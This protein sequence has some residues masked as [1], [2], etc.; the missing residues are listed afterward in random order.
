MRR[1]RSLRRQGP[2]PAQTG[3]LLHPDRAHA[4]TA[5]ADGERDRLDGGRHDPYR[6]RGACCS[7]PTSSSGS[8]PR[9]NIVLRDDKSYPWLMLTEDHAFP[10]IVKHRGAQTRQGQLLGTFRLR[11]GCQPDRD[12]DAACFPAAVLRRYC[13]RQPQP[14]LPAAP[15]PPLLGAMRRPDQRSRVRADSSRRPR[16]FWP[17]RDAP[18][19]ASWR[20]RWRRRRRRS[21]SRRQRRSGTASGRSPSCRAAAS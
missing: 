21:P 11:L 3:D 15:N 6:G 13:I 1:G 20:P 16:A 18:S 2:E 4:G 7:R 10:Q 12:G 9:F 5:A 8:K 17:A 19:S 14:A